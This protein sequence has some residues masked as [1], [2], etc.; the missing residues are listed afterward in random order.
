VE[1]ATLTGALSGERTAAKEVRFYGPNNILKL[2]TRAPIGPDG[3]FRVALPPAGTYRVIITGEPGAQVFTRPE[4][5]I[6][7][8]GADG[9]GVSGI[10]FEVRGRL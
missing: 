3:T 2:Q 1:E 10:D 7:V 6:I 5:R 4:Y 9:K 8:V